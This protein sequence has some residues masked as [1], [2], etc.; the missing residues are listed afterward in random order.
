MRLLCSWLQH[1]HETKFE[2]QAPGAISWRVTIICTS[3]MTWL[4]RKTK[5]DGILGVIAATQSRVDTLEAMLKLRDEG[6][7]A[8]SAGFAM[9]VWLR[10]DMSG[11]V[12]S[13]EGVGLFERILKK[14]KE[15][16]KRRMDRLRPNHKAI[17]ASGA[18]GSKRE[19]GAGTCTGAPWWYA[20]RA[21]TKMRR[22]DNNLKHTILTE[23]A[24]ALG[25]RGYVCVRNTINSVVE[26]I[27]IV[28]ARPC[29][30]DPS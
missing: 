2:Y 14:T 30:A 15:T 19:S 12:A 24:P 11:C 29:A 10:F 18:E 17:I 13:W 7:K 6:A 3:E 28:G 9:L 20:Y 8:T 22:I 4:G 25:G 21:I 1:V 23:G 16:Y 27:L 26:I 5:M